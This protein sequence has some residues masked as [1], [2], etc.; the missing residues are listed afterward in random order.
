MDQPKRTWHGWVNPDTCVLF[1]NCQ[2]DS[3]GSWCVQRFCPP[4]SLDLAV[5]IEVE[6]TQW[7]L[8]SSKKTHSLPKEGCSL[9]RDGLSHLCPKLLVQRFLWG[10]PASLRRSPTGFGTGVFST[11]DRSH[12]NGC[13]ALRIAS[14]YDDVGFCMSFLSGRMAPPTLHIPFAMAGPMLHHAGPTRYCR[15]RTIPCVSLAMSCLQYLRLEP[16]T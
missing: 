8:K 12:R 13:F 10:K 15:I 4:V 6:V 14:C 11:G 3:Y 16:H 7:N 1:C 9:P 2:V 5:R